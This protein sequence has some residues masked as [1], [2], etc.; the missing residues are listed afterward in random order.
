[1]TWSGV[2]PPCM[3]DCR[4]WWGFTRHI[5]GINEPQP[6]LACSCITSCGDGDAKSL[7]CPSNQKRLLS[8]FISL[9]TVTFA[10]ESAVNK[11]IPQES[12]YL[13]C[14][15]RVFNQYKE[16]HILFQLLTRRKIPLILE[17]KYTRVVLKYHMETEF[18]GKFLIPV[19]IF[20]SI[21]IWRR[22]K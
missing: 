19:G 5:R 17:T 21:L 18:V 16:V 20:L 15:P 8:C 4:S 13:C 14:F 11:I 10:I 1:M 9:L 6:H 7:Q 3:R 22:T 12:L 2:T